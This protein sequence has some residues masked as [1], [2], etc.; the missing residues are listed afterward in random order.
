MCLL[1]GLV[2]LL[3]VALPAG[4][5]HIVITRLPSLALGEHMVGRKISF[6]GDL[7]GTILALVVVP[8]PN[9]PIAVLEG[10]AV[11]PDIPENPDDQGNLYN[12]F[13]GL[14]NFVRPLDDIGVTLIDE[15]QSPSNARRADALERVVENIHL[16]H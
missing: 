7:Y 14:K 11:S 3:G 2:V 15:G 1:A 10:S 6:D 16:V 4:S 12:E 8:F 9:E 5:D 13:G